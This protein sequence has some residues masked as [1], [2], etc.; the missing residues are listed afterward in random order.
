MPDLS[1][2]PELL[3][4]PLLISD[5]RGDVLFANGLAQAV[6]GVQ[7]VGGMTIDQLFSETAGGR[8]ASELV[9]EA[10]N[11]SASAVILTRRG[12][13]E[14]ERQESFHVILQP[15]LKQADQ[16]WMIFIDGTL[17]PAPTFGVGREGMPADK[18]PDEAKSD[19]L[20]S[21]LGQA[22]AEAEAKGRLV[23]DVTHEIRNPLSAIQGLCEAGLETS[24]T[25]DLGLLRKIQACANELEETVRDVLEFSR[26]DRGNIIVEE[27]LFDPAVALEEAASHFH[28][29]ATQK[30]LE[31]T[32]FC[33]PDMPR[34]VR[35]DP[36]KLRRIISNLI[37]N[38]VKFTP[39]GQVHAHLR[40]E[41]HGGRL[42]LSLSVRDSGIGIAPDRLERVFEPYMQA[43]AST[44]RRFGG[45]GLGLSIVRG[46][47]RAM[48]GDTRVESEVGDGSTFTAT[49][50]TDTAPM[51]AAPTPKLHQERFLLVGGSKATR[52]WLGECLAHWGAHCRA[53]E[54]YEEGEQAWRRADDEETPYTRAII[55][56]P[57]GISPNL[58]AIPRESCLIASPTGLELLRHAQL[59]K[60]LTLTALRH[61]LA[62]PPPPAANGARPTRTDQ[63]PGRRLRVLI[64][65]DNEVNR[66]VLVAGLRRAGHEVGGAADG[67]G[68]L[69]LWRAKEFDAG[70]FDIQ[71]PVM[72]GIELATALR[73]E[74]RAQSRRRTPLV[75]LTGMS[76]SSDRTHILRVGFDAY[77]AKPAHCRM[78][79]ET[80]D[81]LAAP[82]LA[83]TKEEPR[84]FPSALDMA[85]PEEAE[86]LRCAARAFLRHADD[87]IGRLKDARESGAGP[88]LR[89]EAHGAKGMLALL[90]CRDLAEVARTLEHHPDEPG[91]AT[92][93]DRLIDGLRSLSEAL[94]SRKD[95]SPH[96]Q[97][98]DQTRD[99]D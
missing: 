72:D 79:L 70:I 58:P 71:M 91:A 62:D 12:L 34:A 96:G 24:G 74:E 56:L 19:Q 49:I 31:L 69:E 7:A 33:Q 20:R 68:A 63:L 43:E 44:T 51:T 37:G 8:P 9:G 30:G 85:E 78:L 29:Q 39:A 38:A 25:P 14:G 66:E 28:H 26:L 89:R 95:L 13:D 84:D 1:I 86:D 35:G 23:A 4:W 93:A 16:I 5:R 41:P 94:R 61:A 90:S 6:L 2:L 21:A 54:S 52:L 40:C 48:G 67:V 36:V 76:G 99:Q 57:D 87:M 73:A 65:E 80:I 75:A 10:S 97:A 55:D 59:R 15:D 32:A 46:L 83:N 98:E 27:T 60:P 88:T 42:K 82:E 64:A 3:P 18:L 77:L 50:L 22:R 92:L 17:G 45:T 47:T 81:G 53:V 11:R